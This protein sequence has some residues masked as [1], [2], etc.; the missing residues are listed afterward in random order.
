VT[1]RRATEARQGEH[2][3]YLRTAEAGCHADVIGG[4]P[5]EPQ[6][7][8][9]LQRPRPD[10]A[11]VASAGVTVGTTRPGI[12]DLAV[13]FPGHDA[14]PCLSCPAAMAHRVSRQ[15]V[16]GEHYLGSPVIG[17]ARRG[18][19]AAG[20]LSDFAVSHLADNAI[21]LSHY[22]DHA[23][24]TRSLAIIKTRASSH[25]PAMRQ[26]TI[27]PDGITISDTATPP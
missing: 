17:H 2:R 13:Q 10:G 14:H 3:R 21:M 16:H 5:H 12:A 6:A 8:T 20:S 9:R 1:R 18:L 26:F 11:R 15:L 27:G 25:D 4:I 24:M 22:R 19:P 23:A 7:V